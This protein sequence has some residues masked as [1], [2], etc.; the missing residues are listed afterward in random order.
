M[1]FAPHD[2]A[3]QLFHRKAVPELDARGLRHH[4]LGPAVSRLLG[5][6]R[7]D[8]AEGRGDHGAIGIMGRQSLQ[9]AGDRLQGQQHRTARSG[10]RGDGHLRWATCVATCARSCSAGCNRNI[11][12]RCRAGAT[13]RPA[14]PSKAEQRP[15][16]ALKCVPLRADAARSASSRFSR[17]HDSERASA[18]RQQKRLS[19]GVGRYPPSAAPGH[20]PGGEFL[21]EGSRATAP[22][23][24]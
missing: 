22:H 18:K 3:A 14:I 19:G 2:R 16:R 8:P 23:L 13:K 7:S 17:G 11:P 6:G 10:E 5:A 4:R 21:K 15:V 24:F 12:R 1:G 20:G 9:G